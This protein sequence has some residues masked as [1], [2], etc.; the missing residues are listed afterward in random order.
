MEE[1]SKKTEMKIKESN[2]LNYDEIVKVMDLQTEQFDNES[3]G[4]IRLKKFIDET[5]AEIKSNITLAKNDP[6]ILLKAHLI[7]NL[8][9]PFV[10]PVDID[11][12]C[13]KCSLT[14]RQVRDF[15]RNQRKR[16]VSPLNSQFET[17]IAKKLE[18]IQLL[19]CFIDSFL[20]ELHGSQGSKVASHEENEDAE[21]EFDISNMVFD[22]PALI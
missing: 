20:M 3:E 10:T 22:F 14:K 21:D 5:K 15:F 13:Q 19:D 18:S 4:L 2:H 6:R 12:L 7:H 17:E 11:S 8:N 9:D 16:F 1:C